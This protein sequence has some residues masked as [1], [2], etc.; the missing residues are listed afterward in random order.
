MM[1]AAS[2]GLSRRSS[3]GLVGGEGG[4]GAVG[5]PGLYGPPSPFGVRRGERFAFGYSESSLRSTVNS[6]IL[7]HVREP[8][9]PKTL[10]FASTNSRFCSICDRDCEPV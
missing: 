3:T 6:P 9:L 2:N 1:A 7:I 5:T 10:T 4:D 8:C